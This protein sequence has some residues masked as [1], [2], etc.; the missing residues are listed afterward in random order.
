MTRL[1]GRNATQL[2]AIEHFTHREQLMADQHGVH[3]GHDTLWHLALDVAE[4]SQ[5]CDWRKSSCVNC[6]SGRRKMHRSR[7]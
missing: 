5:S 3:L 7:W 1:L 6:I 4:C 2:A